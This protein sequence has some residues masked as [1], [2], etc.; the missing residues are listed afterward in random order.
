MLDDTHIM[1]LS[2][3]G[4][5]VLQLV[6]KTG[7]DGKIPLL[8]RKDTRLS[9]RVRSDLKKTLE[10]IAATEGRSVAQVC[11]AFLKAGSDTYK[12]EGAEFLQQ[13]LTRPQPRR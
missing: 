12:K 1:I 6:N 2:D 11:E 7:R 9:F 13:L 10:A 4:C 5:Q 8:M 3:N